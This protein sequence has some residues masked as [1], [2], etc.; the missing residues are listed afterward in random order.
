MN[1]NLKKPKILDTT[2]RDGGHIIHNHFGKDT[3]INLSRGLVKSGCDVIELGWLKD[4]IPSDA[5]DYSVYRTTTDAEKNTIHSDETEYSLLFQFDEYDP[6]QLDECG[7]IVKNIRISMHIYDKSEGLRRAHIV[8]NKGYKV[9]IN[10]INFV[11]FTNDEMKRM[12]DDANEFHPHTFSIVDTHGFMNV[13]K[14]LA[15]HSLI[16]ERLDPQ[17]NLALHLHDNQTAAFALAQLFALKNRERTISLDTCIGKLGK[18]CGNLSTEM[19]MEYL[20]QHYGC[21][22]NVKTIYSL[23][24]QNILPIREK[25]NWEFKL[26]YAISAQLCVHQRYADYAVEHKF[27]IIDTYRF[28]SSLSNEEKWRYNEK[29]ADE[30]AKKLRIQ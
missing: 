29:Y 11:G 26:P 14:L 23:F 13:P 19:M 15:I 28:M 21:V 25:V 5:E 9:H 8:K 30:Q 24:E 6:V 1:S 20:N 27:S 18:M 4:S 7:K 12:I 16:S 3:I 17:I 2:L 22:Y 10:P